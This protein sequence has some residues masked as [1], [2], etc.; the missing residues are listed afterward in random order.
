MRLYLIQCV[1][2]FNKAKNL[3][4]DEKKKQRILNKMYRM[5]KEEEKKARK[6][7][8]KMTN[9]IEKKNEVNAEK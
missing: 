9:K 1:Y 4:V 8:T 6:T 3:F 5:K 7:P 2:S